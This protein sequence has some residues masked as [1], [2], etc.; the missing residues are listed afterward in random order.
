M[1][2]CVVVSILTVLCASSVAGCVPPGVLGDIVSGGPETKVPELS[3]SLDESPSPSEEPPGVADLKAADIV[4]TARQHVAD[5]GAFRARLE[6]NIDGY[7]CEYQLSKVMKTG[8]Y[9]FVLIEPGAGVNE[10]LRVDGQLY[11]RGDAEFWSAM[12]ARNDA[13]EPFAQTAGRWVPAEMAVDVL[14]PLST[15]IADITE[16]GSEFWQSLGDKITE[17]E[18]DDGDDIILI[19]G[20][21]PGYMLLVD[22]HYWTPLAVKVPA[23]F[24]HEDGIGQAILFLSEWDTY[25]G[26]SV[27]GSGDAVDARG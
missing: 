11:Y 17:D 8:D 23:D 24:L 18:N 15:D 21:E 2:N 27:P 1:K 13:Y 7:D 12:S 19:S 9:H 25:R 10:D 20:G 14:S 16:Y 26:P 22:A 4:Q 3:D 5:V 6:I